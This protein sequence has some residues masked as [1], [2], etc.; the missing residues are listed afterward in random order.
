M[1]QLDARCVFPYVSK[2]LVEA[3]ESELPQPLGQAGLDQFL[4]A[5]MKVDSADLLDV[6]ADF[7][8]LRLSQL[9]IIHHQ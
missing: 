2:V 3:A 8:E 6:G 1:Y 7:P 9:Q 5:R 4:L